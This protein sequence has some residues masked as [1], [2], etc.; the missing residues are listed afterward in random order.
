M[1][2]HPLVSII[3]PTFNHEKFIGQCIESV[4]A[5]TYSNW[6]QIIIDDGSTDNTGKIVAQYHDNRIKYV[7]QDNAGIW[8]LGETYNK[9][10]R[11]SQGQLI[12]V[13]EG[14]DFW[15]NDKLKKQ[16]LVFN[17]PEIVLSWGKAAVTNSKG[18][19]IYVTRNN[20][21]WFTD[22][23]KTDLLRM[24][25]VENF[26]PA[27]TAI[28]RKDTIISIG[29]FHQPEYAPYVDFPTWLEVILIGEIC[30]VDEIM[31]YWRRHENQASVTMML[32]QVEAH[33]K[34]SID[35]LQNISPTLKNQ[36][37]TDEDLRKQNEFYI[38]SHYFYS[39]RVNL[40]RK[41]W[42]GANMNFKVAFNQGNRFL[43]LKALA[44]IICGNFKLN[45]EWVAL[46]IGKPR[47][48][49]FF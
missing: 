23:T 37:I 27:C 6:E 16:V 22:K 8:K 36:I 34:Y 18:K 3:T 32:E 33:N 21:K 10:L 28:C 30:P 41:E 24:M 25:L 44:G 29:G 42:N 14:D 43:K 39:G 13:L 15:P 17:R 12:A 2:K 9:A 1:I 45:L 38:A 48:N 26:I 19:T 35:F 40:I 49:D 20:L 47:L 4:L 5:Q 7:R 46:L 31:G 11:I